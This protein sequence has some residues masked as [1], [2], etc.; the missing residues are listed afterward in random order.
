MTDEEFFR[1]YGFFLP[2]SIKS[3]KRLSV[4][5]PSSLV[6]LLFQYFE[7]V[8][9][10]GKRHALPLSGGVDSRLLLGVLSEFTDMS[11]ITCFTF[12]TPGSKDFEIPLVLAEKHSFSLVRR[13]LSDANWSIELLM[14]HANDMNSSCRLFSSFHPDDID[15]LE[16]YDFVWSGAFADGIA[17]NWINTGQEFNHSKKEAFENFWAA[18]DLSGINSH[19][20]YQNTIEYVNSRY[21]RSSPING[22]S[23]YETYLLDL[24]YPNLYS[25]NVTPRSDSVNWH[26]P[27]ITEQCI[28]YFANYR[29]DERKKKKKYLK[30]AYESFPWLWET[31]IKARY[32][33]RLGE[34]QINAF[35]KRSWNYGLVSEK[36]KKQQGANYFP[37]KERLNNDR[38]F[39]L[40][41]REF[42]NIN[43]FNGLD[44]DQFITV[45][46]DDFII[47]VISLNV[48][49]NKF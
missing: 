17:G 31:P 15:A 4:E 25:L 5:S 28:N 38:E 6:K 19:S 27:F 24:L 40:L 11:N 32:K 44:F 33:R 37:F 35:L 23:W 21:Q 46:N 26:K 47:N 43:P 1:L 42:Y 13:N 3:T 8:W 36:K 30:E 45:Y 9:I 18:R 48:I 29:I 7:S 14:R 12:G 34:S 20:N 2:D 39:Y 41:I 22:Y 10:H 16:S 49:Q